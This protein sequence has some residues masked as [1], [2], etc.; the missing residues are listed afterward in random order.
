MGY[1]DIVDG[2]HIRFRTVDGLERAP[3]LMYEPTS[4]QQTPTL[5]TLLDRVDRSTSGQVQASLY[6][7]LN[8]IVFQWVDNEKAE[9]EL[10]PYVDS[11]PLAVEADPQLGGIISSGFAKMPEVVAV[12]VS[13]GGTLYRAL[14]CY[15]EVTDKQPYIR[16]A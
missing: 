13:I 1:A 8:R 14:D 5:Y 4:I 2:L 10:M 7:I 16:G 12:F 3:L 15:A 9:E 11:V 6:R